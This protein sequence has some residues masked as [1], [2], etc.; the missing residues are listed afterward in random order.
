MNEIHIRRMSQ[1]TDLAD[2]ETFIAIARTG[3]FR[4]AAA[5]KGVSG[6]A[7]SHAMRNL[8]T[9]LGVRLFHRTSRSVTL[10][11]AGET[12]LADLEPHFS[13]IK[14]AVDKLERFRKGPAGRVRIT[15][16]RD[17]SHLLLSKKLPSF[18]DKY[19][20]IEVEIAV[21]DRFVDM[22][23]E[24]FDAG[25]RYGGTVPEGMIAAKLTDELD[26]VVVGAPSYLDQHG[27]PRNPTDLLEHRCI[28][29]R[30]GTDRIYR[31]E[32]GDGDDTVS[33]DVPGA[34]MLG[35]SELS[36]RMAVSGQ[37]LFYCLRDRV[38]EEL[39]NGDLEV[40]LPEW[41]SKGPGFHAYYASHRQVPS[42]LRT[43]LDHLKS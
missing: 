29:I 5:L 8:E 3:G 28:R 13:G 25:I 35:D 18:I 2:L 20:E 41:A 16:L 27:R 17:A 31:W 24:G 23:A 42:A 38:A 1:R 6:S 12:L 37:G 7:L 14:H 15:A 34:L 30:T 10:T 11:A 19:P 32:L 36:I 21:D 43:L 40:V 9:R 33:L 22:V 4:K 26:W 39:A